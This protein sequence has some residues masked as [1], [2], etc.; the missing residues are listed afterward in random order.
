SKAE[1]DARKGDFQRDMAER[2]KA[3]ERD[4]NGILAP[5]Q[6]ER[7][8]QTAFQMRMKRDG[9]SMAL[10][11]PE[12]MLELGLTE[13][14]ATRIREQISSIEAGYHDRILDL[15]AAMHREI[16][17]QFTAAQQQKLKS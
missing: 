6:Q 15:Q 3:V 9:T 12:M 10:T 8:R 17:A 11:S 1:R 16:L 5:E 2:V 7:L 14:G 13:A 4:I